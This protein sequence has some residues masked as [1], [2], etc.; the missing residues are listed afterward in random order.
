MKKTKKRSL[1]DRARGAASIDAAVDDVLVQRRGTH[2]DFSTNAAVTQGIMRLL[3][4]GP[5]WNL[6]SDVHVEGLHMIAHKMTRVVC[7]DPTEP[8]H[9]AD[10]S[11]YARLVVKHLG[12]SAS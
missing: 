2:G 10:I 9:F 1:L 11:G 6:L 12:G 7:G 8:D 4:T 3:A 5:S